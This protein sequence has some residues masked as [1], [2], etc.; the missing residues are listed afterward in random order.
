MELSTDFDRAPPSCCSWSWLLA[1]AGKLRE[2]EARA[3]ARE[4]MM[5]GSCS[6]RIHEQEQAKCLQ[7]TFAGSIG[8]VRREKSR[9]NFEDGIQVVVLLSQQ[10]DCLLAYST[11]HDAPRFVQSMLCSGASTNIAYTTALPAAR[12]VCQRSHQCSLCCPSP[13]SGLESPSPV[14]DSGYA[15]AADQR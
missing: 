10:Q 9:F 3:S 15:A 8:K 6:T 5:A 2:Q 13:S 14:C 7:A 11:T 12:P 4:S 1:A